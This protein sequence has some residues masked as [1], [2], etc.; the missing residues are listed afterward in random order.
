MSKD[1]PQSDAAQPATPKPARP[2]P[3]RRAMHGGTSDDQE[4]TADVSSVSLEVDGVSWEVQV[5]GRGRGGPA[6]APTPLLLLGFTRVGE[7]AVS[8]E[9]LVVARS[10]EAMPEGDLLLALEGGTPPPDPERE[11]KLFPG[12][13]DGR[14]RKG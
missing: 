8:L 2:T 11:A 5:L 13:T 12:A 14:R 1:A 6:T 3:V 4:G 7:S 10:L 9:T